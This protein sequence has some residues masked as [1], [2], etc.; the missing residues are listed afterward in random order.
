M[1][2]GDCKTAVEIFNVF[3]NKDPNHLSTL[4]FK[5]DCELQLE[6][7][8]DAIES[9]LK[10]LQIEPSLD[11]KKKLALIYLRSGNP[12]KGVELLNLKSVDQLNQIIQVIP[13]K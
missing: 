1:N 12:Q 11:R 4:E 10:I 7:W 9:G 6:R 2:Q 3:L 8:S 5:Q 13:E